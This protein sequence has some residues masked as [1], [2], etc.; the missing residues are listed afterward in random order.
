MNVL[1]VVARVFTSMF[2]ESCFCHNELPKHTQAEDKRKKEYK[3]NCAILSCVI[4]LAVKEKN[5]LQNKLN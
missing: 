4:V 2:T 5:V 3:K 1:V